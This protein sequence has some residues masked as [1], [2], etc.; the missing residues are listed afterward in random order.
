MSGLK[1]TK[2]YIASAIFMLSFSLMGEYRA[3][4]YVVKTKTKNQSDLLKSGD[5]IISST[6]SPTA[7]ISYHGG[8]EIISID[9]INTWM[10]PGNTA[11][12]KICDPIQLEYDGN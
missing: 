12:K 11:R 7:Y 6:L 4:Q 10:C 9:L 1:F 8:S 5:S 2:T 3:Y